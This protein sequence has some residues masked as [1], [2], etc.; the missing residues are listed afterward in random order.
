MNFLVTGATGFIGSK[1]VHFL[2][3]RGDSVNYLGRKRSHTLDSR[4]AFHP[5]DAEQP[6]PLES[7]PGLDAIIHLA[8]E[9]IAQR[10]TGEVKKRIYSSRVD[11]TRNLVSSAAGLP[12]KPR[13][14]VAASAVGYY[15]DRGGEVLTEASSPGSDFLAQ[16]C[17]AWE[18]EAR[19]ATEFDLRVVSVRIATVLGR[20]GGALPRMLTPFRL[21][22]GGQF[23]S[24]RQWWPWIH[25][26]DLV[27]LLVFAAENPALSGPVNGSSPNPVTNA[28]FTKALAAAVH[29]PALFPAPK[30]ALKL[31]L[32]EMADFLFASS[33]V[34]PQAAQ[35]AGFSFNYPELGG[36]LRELVG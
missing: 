15:G 6:P 11:G 24:G 29:R 16:L 20:E 10:W 8:G 33:R 1:V 34:I 19:R 31:A 36:A 3:S 5:W 4:A 25:V 28:D 26:D 2:L 18:R 12:H 32:G 27:R 35:Q 23:G 30:F 13:V 17:V 9:P 22:I 21:G 7:V 14:L